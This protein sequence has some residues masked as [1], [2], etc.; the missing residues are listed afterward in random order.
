LNIDLKIDEKIL[1]EHKT[2]L[3][4]ENDRITFLKDLQNRKESIKDARTRLEHELYEKREKYLDSLKDTAR[5]IIGLSTNSPIFSEFI[6][7]YFEISP[8]SPKP[9]YKEVSIVNL[10]VRTF[11]MAIIGAF[12]IAVIYQPV[13]QQ[14]PIIPRIFLISVSLFIFLFWFVF[15]DKLKWSFDQACYAI[16]LGI[17]AG[18]SG[19]VM[20]S[21]I[22]PEQGALSIYFFSLL[23]NADGHS[24]LHLNDIFR[25]IQIK[26]LI[27]HISH[28][29]K[30][31]FV[32]YDTK[33]LSG[34]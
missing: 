6:L 32:V 19:T 23:D 5:R 8:T 21:I 4:R 12:A 17:V 9:L 20:F 14:Y 13:D 2:N 22:I 30:Q 24:A 15:L 3:N 16:F 7:K 33:R 28:Y 18:A 31:V 1:V 10:L 25:N 29:T 27:T 34:A 26:I 11:S